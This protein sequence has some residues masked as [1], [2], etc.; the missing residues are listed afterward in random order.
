MTKNK[1]TVQDSILLLCMMGAVLCILGGIMIGSF[2]QERYDHEI[3]YIED[4]NLKNRACVNEE[5]AL[6]FCKNL[7]IKECGLLSNEITLNVMPDKS[8]SLNA[9]NSAL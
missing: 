2:I 1:K 6:S 3:Y 7:S 5:G 4:N 9:D 8:M